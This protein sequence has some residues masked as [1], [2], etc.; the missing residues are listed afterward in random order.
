MADHVDQQDGSP[1]PPPPEPQQAQADGDDILNAVR[2]MRVENEALLRRIRALEELP[3]G[4][5]PPRVERIEPKLDGPEKFS[6]TRSKLRN[7]LTDC[8]TVFEGQPHRYATDHSRIFYIAD[9]LSGSAKDWWAVLLDYAADDRPPYYYRYD[10]FKKELERNFGEPDRANRAK[11][12]LLTLHQT[13]SV[14]AFTTLFQR[15][16]LELKWNYDSAPV[17]ALY[18]R[19][20]KGKIKDE[21]A[22]EDIPDVTTDLVRAALAIDNRI[23]ARETERKEEERDRPTPA[24]S[25]TS[26]TNTNRNRNQRAPSSAPAPSRPASSGSTTP[27]PQPF[28]LNRNGHVPPDEMQR[29]IDGGLCRYCAKPGHIIDNCPEKAKSDRTRSA[30]VP[31]TVAA[32]AQAGN[33][34]RA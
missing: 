16:V 15:H 1:P 14:A 17:A 9:R 11:R 2:A 18:Y 29:R 33:G 13:A 31:P 4:P 20:L 28:R 22:R 27:N 24:A 21:L 8:Q 26:N 34:P 7:F 6:G 3:A 5:P 12:A 10:L 19:G 30:S 25:N 23:T 32:S